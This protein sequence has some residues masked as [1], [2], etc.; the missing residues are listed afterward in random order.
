MTL[1]ETRR[2]MSGR[3]KDLDGIAAVIPRVKQK[4]A[5]PDG[6]A[7]ARCRAGDTQAFAAIVER[8]QGMVSG[9]AARAARDPEDAEDVAQEVF[10]R[11]WK[12]LRTFRGDA[13]FSTWLYRI[14]LNTAMRHAGKSANERKRRVEP[15][16]DRADALADLPADPEDGPEATVWRRM[17]NAALREAVHALPE[18]HRAV[19]ILHYFE[20]KT[21]EEIAEIL[22]LS[23]GTVWSRI[24]YAVKKLKGAIA[25]E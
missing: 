9:V 7:I 17:S 2:I 3:R 10:V 19:I 14:A 25:A 21:S 12:S 20:E 8:Y 23:I 6:Q 18:K 16:P 22:G 24:H 11:A 5:D 4:E 15:G 13:K 1:A